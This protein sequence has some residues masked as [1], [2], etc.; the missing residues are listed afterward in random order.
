MPLFENHF[1]TVTLRESKGI[2]LDYPY[3]EYLY[4]ISVL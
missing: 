4:I 2:I 3:M 1:G